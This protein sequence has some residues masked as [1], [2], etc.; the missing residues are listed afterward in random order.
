[1]KTFER[2]QLLGSWESPLHHGAEGA[3]MLPPQLQ[4]RKKNFKKTSQELDTRSLEL[5][6]AGLDI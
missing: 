5:R 2:K 3:G 1:M 6:G 4:P